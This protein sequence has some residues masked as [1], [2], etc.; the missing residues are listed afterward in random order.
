MSFFFLFLFLAARFFLSV[1]RSDIAFYLSLEAWN[2]YRCNWILKMS[3]LLRLLVQR[4]GSLAGRTKK[5]TESIETALTI[6]RPW[7]MST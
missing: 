1:F 6:S 2:Y 5:E 4:T 7:T 3:L